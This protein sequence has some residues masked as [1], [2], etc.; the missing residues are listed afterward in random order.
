MIILLNPHKQNERFLT[1]SQ[2]MLILSG[3][4]TYKQITYLYAKQ[5]NTYKSKQK[6]C[7]DKIRVTCQYSK[8][9]I[10]LTSY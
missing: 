3:M 5:Y 7:A 9:Q 1:I 6:G 4:L 2:T 10:H 8:N